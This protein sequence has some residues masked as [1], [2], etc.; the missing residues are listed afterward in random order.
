MKKP[1]RFWMILGPDKEVFGYINVNACGY[2]TPSD[3]ITNLRLEDCFILGHS[4]G[5]INAK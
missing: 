2:E 5:V 4:V 3:A 1:D